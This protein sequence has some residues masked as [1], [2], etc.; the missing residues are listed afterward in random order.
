MLVAVATIPIAIG[1]GY[2]VGAAIKKTGINFLDPAINTAKQLPKIIKEKML[3]LNAR[4]AQ[5]NVKEFAKPQEKAAKK[6][7]SEPNNKIVN[8]SKTQNK[9]NERKPILKKIKKQ[10]AAPIGPKKKPK[11]KV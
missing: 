7:L 8:L 4:N 3:N 9:L 10:H 6:N 2:V 5:K 11:V 1:A